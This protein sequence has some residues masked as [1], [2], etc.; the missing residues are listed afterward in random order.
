MESSDRKSVG[1]VDP[2]GLAE[3]IIAS[4]SDTAEEWKNAMWEVKEDHLRLNDI[5][6]RVMLG[7]AID[8]SASE[9]DGTVN[10]VEERTFEPLDDVGLFE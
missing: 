8:N 10:I 5:L 2:L 7:K 1:L 9:A 6:I 4:R 3:R